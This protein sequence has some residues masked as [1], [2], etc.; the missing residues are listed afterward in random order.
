M[1]DVNCSHRSKVQ[2]IASALVPLIFII[3]LSDF[4]VAQTLL[5][6]FLFGVSPLGTCRTAK[7]LV[8]KL[9]AFNVENVPSNDT[10]IIVETACLTQMLRCS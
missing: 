2:G 1:I 7:G 6:K 8:D 5:L 9:V 3:P 10:T 4:A